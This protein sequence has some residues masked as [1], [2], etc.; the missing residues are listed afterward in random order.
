M[1]NIKS[2]RSNGK[3]S[4]WVNYIYNTLYDI[5]I[6]AVPLITT[7]YI[8]RVMSVES[9]G[10]GSYTHSQTLYFTAFVALG[11]KSYAIK[12]IARSQ[13]PTDISQVFWN[14]FLLRF[15]VGVIAIAVYFFSVVLKTK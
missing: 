10:I 15:G 4:V 1:K 8:S 13:T 9:I 6:I 2:N 5:L 11:T 14:V 12:K 3:A 7:P